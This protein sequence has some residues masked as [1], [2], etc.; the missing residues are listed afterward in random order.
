[1]VVSGKPE[2]QGSK[3]ILYRGNLQTT[4]SVRNSITCYIYVARESREKLN[5]SH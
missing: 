3:S 2:K 4:L 5:K 1:M